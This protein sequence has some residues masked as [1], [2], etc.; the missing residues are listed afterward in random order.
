M[1]QVFWL[2][3]YIFTALCGVG[4][5]RFVMFNISRQA[6]TFHIIFDASLV[7][8]QQ[9]LSFYSMSSCCFTLEFDGKVAFIV[10]TCNFHCA[11]LN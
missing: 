9:A 11:A 10:Q 1:D 8:D 2:S 3:K 5:E 7:R 6:V 4:E